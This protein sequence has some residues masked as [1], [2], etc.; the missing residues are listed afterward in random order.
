MAAKFAPN[1][2][3]EVN[4][5]RHGWLP[6]TFVSYVAGLPDEDFSR[7]IVEM[8]NAFACQAV[9][10]HPGCVRVREDGE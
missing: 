7:C 3:V 2:R 8:D 4:W 1:Q 6:G 9:G 5:H 10:F